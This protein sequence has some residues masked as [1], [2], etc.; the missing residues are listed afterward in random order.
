MKTYNTEILHI[1]DFPLSISHAKKVIVIL[2][3]N[4]ILHKA[5][6]DYTF[7]RQD[8]FFINRD[9]IYAMHGDCIAYIVTFVPSFLE[10]V[11]LIDRLDPMDQQ[12]DI[13]ITYRDCVFIKS[14]LSLYDND[15]NL[16]EV[17]D[18]L[19]NDYNQINNFHHQYLVASEKDRLLYEEV[20]NIIHEH[21]KERIS[22]SDIANITGIQKNRL[23]NFFHNFT[24]NTV[25]YHLNQYRLSIAIR[26]MLTEQQ[27]NDQLITSC[28]FTDRK[29]YYRYFK[30]TFHTTPDHYRMEMGHWANTE[31]CQTGRSG[32]AHLRNLQTELNS[33]QTDTYFHERYRFI[34]Q[35][36]SNHQIQHFQFFLNLLHPSNY[37][38]AEGLLSNTW[39]GFDLIQTLLSEYDQPIWLSFD[40]T[41]NT[42]I[43]A[44]DEVLRLLETSASHL[45]HHCVRKWQFIIRIHSIQQIQISTYIRQ[46]LSVIFKGHTVILS[47]LDENI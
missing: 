16:A 31:F 17:T 46:R 44:I 15:E 47:N 28:G 43:S 3:G 37:L 35:I 7:T 21:Y 8:V 40:L 25:I 4:C 38:Y 36:I 39:Y 14:V 29:Y 5:F 45:P 10:N 9:E 1:K 2:E 23:A 42:T 34:Q 26:K 20:I 13:T 32:K 12:K 18:A 33:L 41:N 6:Q 30:E 22:L 19:D 27:T 24:G 11:K